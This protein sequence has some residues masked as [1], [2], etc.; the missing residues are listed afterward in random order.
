MDHTTES[1]FDLQATWV[2]NVFGLLS[3]MLSMG[4]CT[5]RHWQASGRLVQELNVCTAHVHQPS[6][7][8]GFLGHVSSGSMILLE[9]TPEYHK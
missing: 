3:D 2:I 8:E 7:T 6:H 5:T 1:Y 9:I 4:V